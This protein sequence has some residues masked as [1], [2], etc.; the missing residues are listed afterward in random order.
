MQAK[1]VLFL[2]P[3]RPL[4]WNNPYFPRQIKR[5]RRVLFMVISGLGVLIF[6]QAVQTQ[7]WIGFSDPLRQPETAG[8]DFNSRFSGRA[9]LVYQ[10]GYA[11][12]QTNLETLFNNPDAPVPKAHQFALRADLRL[13]NTID[14][15]GV[16]GKTTMGNGRIGLSWLGAKYYLQSENKNFAIRLAIKPPI[17]EPNISGVD[18]SGFTETKY[19]NMLTTEFGIGFRYEQSGLSDFPLVNPETGYRV[20]QT[21]MRT[22]IRNLHATRTYR[23]AFDPAA[24]NLFVSLKA[25][26]GIMESITLEGRNYEGPPQKPLKAQG[27]L[28]AI[29]V[30]LNMLRPTW[31][32]SPY[33]RLP[34]HQTGVVHDAIRLGTNLQLR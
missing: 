20:Q 17:A 19:P 12:Q 8:R 2:S 7:P 23:F 33:F 24:S 27:G 30:G 13:T 15:Q 34:L 21:F 22:S 32:F 6:A 26:V 31:Q 18:I 28:L 3:E 4:F 14:L 5:L 25:S 10:P 16:W 29:E 9:Y 1:M 11:L